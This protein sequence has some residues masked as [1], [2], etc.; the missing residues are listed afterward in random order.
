MSGIIGRSLPVRDSRDAAIPLLRSSIEKDSRQPLYH[1]H[2]GLAYA[3]SGDKE[4]ARES[5]QEAIRLAPDFAGSADA[6]RVLDT[7]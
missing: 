3:K 6:R 4:R 5:L 7:L 1:Y 2:L